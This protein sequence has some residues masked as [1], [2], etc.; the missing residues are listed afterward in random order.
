MIKE[1]RNAS[2]I[3]EE[4]EHLRDRRIGERMGV[5]KQEREVKEVT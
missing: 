3:R 5:R 2:G 4:R 1:R